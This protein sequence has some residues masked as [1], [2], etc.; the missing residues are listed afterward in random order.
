MD[1]VQGTEVTDVLT[2]PAHI[3]SLQAAVTRLHDHGL[4][5]G[6]LR[7]SN[8][9]IVEDRVMLDD[10]DW[11]G[12]ERKARYPSDILLLDPTNWHSGVRRGRPI[13]KEHDEHS[14]R[15]ITKQE[16]SD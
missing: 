13:L 15:L 2:D 14:F 1:Y 12:K 16:L 10:L 9:L 7:R 5:F 8:L 3:A 6:D 11:C 4:V